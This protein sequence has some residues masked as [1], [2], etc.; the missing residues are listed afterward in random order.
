MRG[1]LTDGSLVVPAARSVIPLTIH[2]TLN[3]GGVNEATN[4]RALLL[5]VQEREAARVLE[6]HLF[7]HLPRNP[8]RV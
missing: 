4:I 5:L 2:A 8:V 6:L 1:N 3:P 7:Q